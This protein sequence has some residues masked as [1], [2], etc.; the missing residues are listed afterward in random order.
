MFENN[1]E[2][3]DASSEL[4]MSSVR[5]PYGSPVLVVTGVSYNRG[6]ADKT[7]NANYSARKQFINCSSID[8]SMS[9]V[10]SHKSVDTPLIYAVFKENTSYSDF[11]QYFQVK[12]MCI[13]DSYFLLFH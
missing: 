11:F 8:L 3:S 4:Q 7:A 5:R 13:H 6:L 9:C 12:C 2:P 10:I 1:I